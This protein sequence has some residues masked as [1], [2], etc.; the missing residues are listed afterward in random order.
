MES[1]SN[2]SGLQLIQF[3]EMGFALPHTLVSN[4]SI[5]IILSIRYSVK[6]KKMGSPRPL[7]FSIRNPHPSGG[8][9]NFSSF[10][11]FRDPPPIHLPSTSNPPPI[12]SHPML[13]VVDIKVRFSSDEDEN[14]E[15]KI[16]DQNVETPPL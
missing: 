16:S 2:L 5:I 13:L 9:L 7:L 1:S 10:R 14:D 6:P 12:L 15:K 4:L 11:P 3:Y 8:I